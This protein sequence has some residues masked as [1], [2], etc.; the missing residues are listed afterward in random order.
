[1]S[2]VS[3]VNFN[4]SFSTHHFQCFIINV[5]FSM[6]HLRCVIYNV[7][8]SMCHF[9]YVIFN[10]SLSMCHFQCSISNVSSSMCHFE[11][12]NSNVSPSMRHLHCVIFNVSLSLILSFGLFDHYNFTICLHLSRLL[13]FHCNSHHH[14]DKASPTR[15]TEEDEKLDFFRYKGSTNDIH[16][17]SVLSHKVK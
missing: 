9:Q 14:L 2:K 13:M 8:S 15:G 16:L 3:C 7:L 5:L 12:V 6:Y 17:L 4:V 1:M 11:S 10:F